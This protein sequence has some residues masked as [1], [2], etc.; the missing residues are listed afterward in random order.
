MLHIV[1]IIFFLFS[2]IEFSL[3]DYNVSKRL[4]QF[5][6]PKILQHLIDHD[7]EYQKCLE[8]VSNRYQLRKADVNACTRVLYHELSKHAHG[9]TSSL[10]VKDTEH[11]VTEVAALEAVFCALKKQECF[12]LPLK[13]II[14]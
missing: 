2:S 1:N 6:K 7:P 14:E 10:C 13:L 9:N 12:R 11:T 5:S 4:K 3:D 8:S